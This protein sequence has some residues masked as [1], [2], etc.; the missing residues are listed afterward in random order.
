MTAVITALEESEMKR[1]VV[2][3]AI[4]A[5]VASPL[6][7]WAGEK[8]GKVTKWETTTRTVTL[9]DGKTY[10]FTE[11]VKTETIKEGSRIKVTY[12][13]KDGKFVATKYEILQ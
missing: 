13:E 3:L 5:V 2:A 10:Q 12:E 1:T 8:E 11:T 6:G 4:A 9:D 7:A